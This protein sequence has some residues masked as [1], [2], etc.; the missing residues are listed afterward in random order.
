M[1]GLAFFLLF[2]FL[3]GLHGCVILGHVEDVDVVPVANGLQQ[4]EE[5][6]GSILSEECLEAIKHH[7]LVAVTELKRERAKTVTTATRP[8]ALLG[9]ACSLVIADTSDAI[10]SAD[11]LGLNV[12]A[13]ELPVK[14]KVLL[15]RREK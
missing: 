8:S 5:S 11:P 7:A 2:G 1:W 10:G 14:F 3:L 15:N 9:V 12:N 13:I 6:N 4:A